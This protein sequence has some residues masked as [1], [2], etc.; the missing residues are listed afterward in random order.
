MLIGDPPDHG[1]QE[2]SV[3]STRAAELLSAALAES[4]DVGDLPVR[5]VWACARVLPVTGAG[6]ALMTDK[7]PA[8]TV[9]ATDGPALELEELQFTLGEG[10]CVDA[11]RTGRPVLDGIVDLGQERDGN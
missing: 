7:G 2:V 9:A 3:A 10:P 1:G 5:L 8:G 11:S 4:A 6:L